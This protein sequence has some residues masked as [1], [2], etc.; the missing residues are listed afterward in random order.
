[1]FLLK[2]D[3][4]ISGISIESVFVTEKYCISSFINAK[5]CPSVCE[6][7]AKSNRHI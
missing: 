1:M 2:Q 3:F 7:P 5:V 4:Q 6:A